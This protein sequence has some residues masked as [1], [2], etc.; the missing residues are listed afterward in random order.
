MKLMKTLALS[1][2]IAL[3]SGPLFAAQQPL[4]RIAAI[5]NNDVVMLSEVEQRIASV[6]AQIRARDGVLPPDE[7]LK[8]QV[9]ERLVMESIQLQMGERAG[10]RIDDQTLNETMARIAERNNMSLTQFKETLEADGISYTQAR[11]QVRRDLTINRIRQARVNDRIHISEQEVRNFEFSEEGQYQLSAD[12]RLTH[13]LVPLPEAPSPAQIA[14]AQQT[15]GEIYQK[16]QE[17]ANFEQLALTYSS[18]RSA[19]EGGDLGWR[20]ADQL[21]SLFAKQAKQMKVGDIARPMRTASGFHIIK[22]ADVRGDNTLIQR[23][24]DVR[25]ILI[26]PNEIRRDE[27]A[28]RLAAQLYSRIE[29]GEDFADLARAHSDD[30]GSALNGGRLDWVNPDDLVPEFQQVMKDTPH[31]VVS[32]P[33]KSQYGWHILEVLGERS[34]DM[35]VAVKENRI[36]N[37]LHER[38]FE[39]E[40]ELWLREIRDD[41]FVELKI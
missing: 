34:R 6:K 35:S 15:A 10:I 25:H 31:F 26:K 1:A 12:Y 40:V 9:L 16:L 5:V 38:K 20:K 30:T 33:F 41:T 36:R 19:L 28:R 14:T 39:E 7:I 29:A 11:E 37:I 32:E 2:S 21:P 22:L 17:G 23:Q 3:A 24:Y 4:D 8:E 18:G 27:D 13:I